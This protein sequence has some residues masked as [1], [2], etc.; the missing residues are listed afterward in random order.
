MELAA[1][2]EEATAEVAGQSVT[3]EPH[4][5]IVTKVEDESVSVTVA[6]ETK[7]AEAKMATVENCIMNMLNECK[8]S[9]LKKK[10]EEKNC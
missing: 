7:A 10:E 5:V 8:I 2:D 9:W 3:S 4:E 1:T 6:A